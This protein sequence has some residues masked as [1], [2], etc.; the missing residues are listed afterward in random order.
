MSIESAQAYVER[1]SSDEE[2]ARKVA[3]IE[4]REERAEMARSEGFDFTPE[5]LQKVTTELSDEELDAVAGGWGGCGVTHE[6][7]ACSR[8]CETFD[9]RQIDACG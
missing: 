5:E 9:C 3:A 1:L 8:G 6:S 4:T 2:F 7:E